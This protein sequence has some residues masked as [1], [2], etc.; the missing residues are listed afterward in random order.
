MPTGWALG[1]SGLRDG[2]LIGTGAAPAVPAYLFH[3]I[4]ARSTGVRRCSSS[5]KGWRLDDGLR[6]QLREWLNLAQEERVGCL[7]HAVARRYRRTAIAR[8]SS[9]AVRPSLPAEQR[10]IE[11]Q[12]TAIYRRFGST[13]VRSRSPAGNA[14]ARLLLPVPPRQPPV[15]TR[16]RRWRSPDGGLVED[17]PGADRTASVAEHGRGASSP[18]GFR[19]RWMAWATSSRTSTPGESSPMNVRSVAA[20]VVAGC[21][22][23]CIAAFRL[24]L[25]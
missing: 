20:S 7:C 8:P 9:R 18:A 13:T 23:H 1:R 25:R 19:P 5:M 4:E 24:P 3:R 12:I 17:R 16:P 2:G 15:R 22:R 14:K 10:A 21:P 6:G 11:P